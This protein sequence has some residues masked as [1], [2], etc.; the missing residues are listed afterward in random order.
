MFERFTDRA[1]RV[2]VLAQEEARMLNHNYI[3]TEHI[4]LGLI[5]EGEGVA[6]KALESLGISLDAVRQQ[7]E[8]IIGQGQQAPSGHIPFTPR[9]KK[10][11]ELSLREALQLGHNYIGTEH[12]LLGLIREG[13]GVAAQVLMKLGAD[14]SRV[15]QQVIQLLHGRGGAAEEA[16]AGTGPG[17]AGRIVSRER[18]LLAELRKR[19]D[20]IDAR[21]SA[22]ER[23]V[24]TGP[25]TGD[26]DAEV[27]TVRRDKAA[28]LGREDYEHAAALRDRERQ[29]LADKA[30]RQQEWAAAHPDL[31]S[32]AERVQQLGEEIGQL[33]GLLRQDGIEPDDGAG[34]A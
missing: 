21:L 23:R 26:L 3:G 7:V 5:H 34:A 1:R 9:A 30:A 32:L 19:V 18:R 13:D 2:V 12:I 20:A 22:A 15:R 14:L 24:G 11:L 31:T 4:L 25:D 6:A 10:V 33:R 17:P 28:A 29:L 8:E 27:A 16:E